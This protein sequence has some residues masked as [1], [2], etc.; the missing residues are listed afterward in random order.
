M[1][2]TL[3]GQ[4]LVVPPGAT[5]DFCREPAHGVLVY[6]DRTR[7]VCQACWVCWHAPV[8]EAQERA[9]QE[10]DHQ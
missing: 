6:V 10:G 1:A 5:C 9:G 7:S 3:P 8:H 4:H 2:R